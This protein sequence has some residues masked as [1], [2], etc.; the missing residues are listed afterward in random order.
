[1]ALKARLETSCVST[2][3]GRSQ[4][5]IVEGNLRRMRRNNNRHRS[6]YLHPPL[7]IYLYLSLSLYIC[8]YKGSTEYVRRGMYVCEKIEVTAARV[9]TMENQARVME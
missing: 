4:K 8:V 3:A 9:L 6:G 1:M 2:P 5:K 7:S